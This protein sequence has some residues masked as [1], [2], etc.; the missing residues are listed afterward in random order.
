MKVRW[1]KQSKEQLRQTSRYIHLEIGKRAKEVFMQAVK[2]TNDLLAD[3]P[4][5]GSPE[6]LLAD[7]PTQYRSVVVRRLSK[8]VYRIVD[9]HIEVIA[10]WD[11]R[12]EPNKL[13]QEL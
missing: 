9:N 7:L 8:I 10:F 12:R 13:V 3:N 4:Q 1:N 2:Q 11:C 6:I 5:L